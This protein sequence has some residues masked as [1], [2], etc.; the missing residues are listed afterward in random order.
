MSNFDC[1]L[2][3][4]FPYGCGQQGV[5]CIPAGTYPILMQ[6]SSKRAAYYN[7]VTLGSQYIMSVTFMSEKHNAMQ[8]PVQR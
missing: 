7:A 2:T 1:S 4:V 8:L 5:P 6:Y 3:P